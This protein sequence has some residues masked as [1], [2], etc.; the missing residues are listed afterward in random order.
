[1]KR[2]Q[3]SKWLCNEDGA[4]SVLIIFMMIVLVTLG[5]FAITSANVNIKFSNKAAAWSEKY[6]LLDSVGEQYAGEIDY[7]LARA[8]AKAA[9]YIH[10]AGYTKTSY[11]GVTADAQREIAALWKD[12]GAMHTIENIFNRVYMDW[13]YEEISTLNA[14][15]PETEIQLTKA[16]LVIN[17]MSVEVNLGVD[18]NTDYQLCVKLA[19][20]VPSY[21]FRSEAN[22]I[23]MA[24]DFDATR[25]VVAD[26]YQWQVPKEY[27]SPYEDVWDGVIN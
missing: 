25:Y 14:L 7:A 4:T 11:D 22:G 6:Y 27:T 2:S 20:R 10:A 21:N 12:E 5:A 16:G 24:K 18:E 9:E 15:Y 8:E 23:S 13:A 17:D 3:T 26:W 19:V 1:M